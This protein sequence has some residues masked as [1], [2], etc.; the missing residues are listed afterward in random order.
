MRSVSLLWL[1]WASWAV[2]LLSLSEEGIASCTCTMTKP[3]STSNGNFGISDSGLCF[4][5]PKVNLGRRAVFVLA[6]SIRSAG[7]ASVIHDATD[8]CLLSEQDVERRHGLA[9][10]AR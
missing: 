7:S 2:S 1:S 6:K 4:V 3:G 9:D 10:C 5:P 8:L